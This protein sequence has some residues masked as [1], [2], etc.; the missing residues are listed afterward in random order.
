M[1]P[2]YVAAQNS[3]MGRN[4][5]F[6]SQPFLFQSQGYV[7]QVDSRMITGGNVSVNDTS[8]RGQE[9]QFN[10]DLSVN[11]YRRNRCQRAS[12]ACSSCAWWPSWQPVRRSRKNSLS[13]SPSPSR[14]SR[15]ILAN[16]SKTGSGPV[17]SR[18]TR[19]AAP[20]TL[21]PVAARKGGASC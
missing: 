11:L 6:T 3:S 12:R 21:L 5:P 2:Q 15:P 8:C 20:S 18:L 9:R 13:C 10:A 1:Y 14:W 16:T 19:G 17:L 7:C 4:E